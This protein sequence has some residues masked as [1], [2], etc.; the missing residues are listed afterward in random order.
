MNKKVN[1]FIETIAPIARNEY[2]S[3]N[4]WV[5]PSICIAQAGLE[6]GWNLSAKTLFGIKGCG[7]KCTTSEYLKGNWVRIEAS[8]KSYPNVT[9][10]V[11]GY[12]DFLAKTPRYSKVVNNPFY[13][14][15]VEHLIKTNDGKPYATDPEYVSKVISVIE[16]YNLT[17]YDNTSLDLSP[18]LRTTEAVAKEC[19]NG[20]WGSGKEREIRLTKAGYSYVTIQRLINKLI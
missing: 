3:R 5:L 18:C 7:N 12:Y 11:I 14:D 15:A 2:L 13:K 17:I 8:F 6:S 16:K 9:S 19:I 4:R 10:S 1:K 20:L